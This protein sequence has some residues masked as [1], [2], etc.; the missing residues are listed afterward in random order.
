MQAS[1]SIYGTAPPSPLPIR[2]LTQLIM[3][4][5]RRGEAL[6]LSE[7]LQETDY[8][9]AFADLAA[10]AAVG[11]AGIAVAT[12]GDGTVVGSAY[13]LRSK[14]ATEHV[15]AT[16]DQVVVAP[17]SRRQG[18]AGRIVESLVKDGTAHGIE[19][20]ELTVRS[21]NHGAIRLYERIGFGRCGVLPGVIA[22]GDLRHDSVVMC[23][24]EGRPDRVRRVFGMPVGQGA[25]F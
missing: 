21:N 23:R 12:A 11:N 2:G 17:D 3:D 6:G 1:I 22:I 18:I 24:E 7:T 10:R 4:S 20:F 19:V 16:V 9:S 14:Y 8:R 13:W 15:L 5:V 25:S